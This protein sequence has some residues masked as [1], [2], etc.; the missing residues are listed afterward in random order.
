MPKL[1]LGHTPVYNENPPKSPFTKGGL[2]KAL[3]GFCKMVVFVI[4]NEVK[5]LNLL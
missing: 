5:E 4:L 3:R 2:L 1:Q